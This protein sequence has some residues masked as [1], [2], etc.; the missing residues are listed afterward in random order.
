MGQLLYV[1]LRNLFIEIMAV[2]IHMPGSLIQITPIQLCIFTTI[3][4][5]IGLKKYMHVYVANRKMIV[6]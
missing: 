5:Q 3:S 2:N 1:T 4:K 6:I